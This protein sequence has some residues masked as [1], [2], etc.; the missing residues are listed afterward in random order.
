MSSPE[1]YLGRVHALVWAIADKL[2]ASERAEVQHLIDHG[3]PAE[4][5]RALAWII[6]EGEKRVPDATIR[7]IRELSEGLVAPEHLPADLE[8]HTA[9]PGR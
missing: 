9:E 5:L 7:G 1:D 8:S 4:A 6:T 2:S 3:E